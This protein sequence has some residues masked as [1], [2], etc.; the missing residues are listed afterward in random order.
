MIDGVETTTEALLA[1]SVFPATLTIDDITVT[2]A[3][4]D[5]LTGA[6]TPMTLTFSSSQLPPPEGGGL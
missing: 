4:K 3:T 5:A 2:G 1:F 6:G